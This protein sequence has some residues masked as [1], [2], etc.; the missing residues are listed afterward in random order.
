VQFQV[1][2]EKRLAVVDVTDRVEGALPA[3]AAGTATV[4]VRHTTAAVTVN[5]AESRL[6]TDFET[7]LDDIVPD[8]GWA[9]DALDGNADA[10]VRAMLVGPSVTVPVRSGAIDLGTWQSVLLLECDGPRER[11]VDVILTG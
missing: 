10:H 9:H 1:S 3:E 5:E 6:L 2:T 8:S 7:A 11:T 4:F